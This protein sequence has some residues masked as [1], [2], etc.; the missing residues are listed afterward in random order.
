[1]IAANLLVEELL[2]ESYWMLLPHW[3][4]ILRIGPLHGI[5]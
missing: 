4:R 3:A 1:M 5:Y 2:S